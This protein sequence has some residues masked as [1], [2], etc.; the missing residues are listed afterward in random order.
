LKNHILILSFSNYHIGSLS[1]RFNQHFIIITLEHFALQ[2]TK[3][4]DGL[5]I[6]FVTR[7]THVRFINI[8]RNFSVATSSGLLMSLVDEAV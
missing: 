6:F 5:N 8:F 2:P 4:C 1:Q 7:P 3:E